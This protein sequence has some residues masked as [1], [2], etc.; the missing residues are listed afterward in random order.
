MLFFLLQII[1]KWQLNM[2][3]GIYYN[4][5]DLLEMKK[6]KMRVKNII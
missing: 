6:L 5:E 3:F 1:L 2:E 4:L